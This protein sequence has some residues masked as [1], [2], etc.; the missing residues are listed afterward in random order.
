[1]QV[2][3]L[4]SSTQLT[5]LWLFI[6]VSKFS[7]KTILCSLKSHDLTWPH[8]TSHDVTWHHMGSHDLTWHHMTSH[9][10]TWAHMTSHDC[11]RLQQL[12]CYFYSCREFLVPSVPSPV[13]GLKS[14][15]QSTSTTSIVY[16]YSG[17]CS[18]PWKPK[19]HNLVTL[20]NNRTIFC[21]HTTDTQSS[22]VQ[23]SKLSFRKKRQLSIDPQGHGVLSN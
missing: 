7:L 16:Q 20:Q 22:L 23:W 1:M 12:T 17:G 4:V 6:S 8:M 11:F 13:H 3:R 21:L 9:D 18:S 5:K 19:P 2:C 15:R 10:T 14:W